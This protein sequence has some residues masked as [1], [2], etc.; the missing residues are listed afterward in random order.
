MTTRFAL[1][2][3]LFCALAAATT[4]VPASSGG[5]CDNADLHASAEDLHQV[6]PDLTQFGSA[7]A[8]SGLTAMVG[9]PNYFVNPETTPGPQGRV[10]IFTCDLQTRTWSRVGSLD[11]QDPAE[12]E[13]FFGTAIALQG[14]QAAIGSENA[15]HLY[16][17]RHGKWQLVLHLQANGT[18]E[19]IEPRIAYDRP[20]LAVI[21]AKVVAEQV[22]RF[23]DVYRVGE[24]RRAT[25]VARL[26][27]PGDF[28]PLALDAGTLVAGTFVYTKRD[29][30]WRLQQEIAPDEAPPPDSDFGS[31]VAIRRNI[32]LVG[33]PREDRIVGDE[34]PTGGGAVYVFER[35]K[36]NWR[37]VQRIR[38]GTAGFDGFGSSLALNEH[39]AAVGAP[40]ALGGF[41]REFGPTFL[42]RVGAGG[43]T[44]DST[45]DDVIATSMD[46]SRRDLIVGTSTVVQG[47]PITRAVIV[48][49]PL[50][51]GV[52]E[53]AEEEGRSDADE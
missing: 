5:F 44:F 1:L 21:R 14:H 4:P 12:E 47:S 18:D 45:L 24:G 2:V 37:Q 16:A 7:V 17:E 20:Y 49:L 19:F 52:A 26:H 36:G 29:G 53:S 34:G 15:V 11:P 50:L 46:M 27:P 40:G 33:S 28:G 25:L 22:M 30:K 9:L 10:A 31:V 41:G 3:A 13:L 39:H 35:R 23:I 8:I 48:R 51:H 43:L 6:P 38:P 42:Y 32:L